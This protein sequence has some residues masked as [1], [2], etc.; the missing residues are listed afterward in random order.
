[1][2]KKSNRTWTARLFQ[3]G[4]EESLFDLYDSAFGRRPRMDEWRWQFFDNPAGRGY[5][6][7]AVD[8]KKIVG[9][10]AVIPITMQIRNRPQR[11]AQS[12]DTMTHP[13]YRKQGIFVTLASGV[14]DDARSDNVGLIYGFPNG[15]SLHG[16]IERL[17]FFVLENLVS[18]TRPLNFS[19]LIG[20]K[21]RNRTLSTIFGAPVKLIFNALF[22]DSPSNNIDICIKAAASFPEPTD[23]LFRQ[24]SPKFKNMIVR[25]AQYLNWRYTLNPAKKYNIY[26]AY[27]GESLTGYCV[28]GA[29]KMMG[30]NVGLIMDILTD[31][32]DKIVARELLAH[33]IRNMKREGFDLA[34]CILPSRS[35]FL[36]ILKKLGFIMA[37]KKFPFILHIN[38]KNISSSDIEN[39]KDW[40]ITY[41]DAD[42]V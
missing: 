1:M 29:R 16:F 8:R 41:G 37:P 31:P 38:A 17:D 42:F 35:I 26:L 24:L 27:R 2:E 3:E 39:I 36:K 14:Y 23:D 9:Q 25:D 18:Y 6:R 21:L 28:C 33:S 22:S 4:D 7:L 32:E 5:I 15:I 13:D 34:T 19:G 11:A 20:T 12:L 30:S 40:H 10:Y